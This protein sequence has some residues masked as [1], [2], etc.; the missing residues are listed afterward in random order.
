MKFCSY[1]GEQSSRQKEGQIKG[2]EARECLHSWRDGLE[3]GVA[4]TEGVQGRMVGRKIREPC[5][6]TD[7]ALVGHGDNFGF[8]P[9]LARKPL[10]SVNRGMI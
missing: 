1:R 6:G 5:A 4:G 7:Q 3:A 2:L 9:E 10:D 8:D